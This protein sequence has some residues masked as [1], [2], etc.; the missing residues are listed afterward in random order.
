MN[1][2]SQNTSLFPYLLLEA[3]GPSAW[4]TWRISPWCT[5]LAV[6]ILYYRCWDKQLLLLDH[7]R[8][9]CFLVACGPSGKVK[10][11]WTLAIPSPARAVVIKYQ[12]QHGFVGIVV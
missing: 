6:C 12:R 5:I 11:L 8:P 3:W 2:S 9:G 10:A 7:S 1:L 4:R